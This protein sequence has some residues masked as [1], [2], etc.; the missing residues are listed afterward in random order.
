MAHSEA[1]SRLLDSADS[2]QIGFASTGVYWTVNDG[3]AEADVTRYSEGV[4]SLKATVVNNPAGYGYPGVEMRIAGGDPLTDWSSY[5]VL[6][7]DVWPEVNES[8]RDQAPDLYWF[9]LYNA[10]SGGPVTQG[11]PPL[12]LDRWNRASVSLNPLHKYWSADGLDLSNITR[13]EFHTR[14]NETVSGNSGLWDDGD[15]LT[16]WLDN[17]RLVDQDSGALNWMADGSSS[18]YYVY[19][20]TLDHEGHPAPTLD[21]S[22]SAPTLVGTVGSTEA[23]GYYH[24]TTGAT[25]LGSLVVWEAPCVEKILPSFATPLLSDQ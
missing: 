2:P 11:G 23:G 20:D 17:I 24:R 1:Y 16:L 21:G 13:A 25:N 10:V 18:R 8:A 5:E 22:L 4:G 6:V 3:S 9:K 12:V 14:D 19:F 15:I 7:Y